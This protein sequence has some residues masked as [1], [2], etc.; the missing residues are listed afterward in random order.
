M[1]AM[2]PSDFY[3]AFVLRILRREHLQADNLASIRLAFNV[4]VAA[5]HLA[6]HYFRYFEK[7]NADFRRRYGK[8]EKGL[9]KFQAKLVGRESHFKIIQDMAKI[10]T[11]TFT[12]GRLALLHPAAILNGWR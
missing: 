8:E 12:L 4:A 3:E 9:K 11:N 6:D 1:S 10:H 2:T 7:R 5:F